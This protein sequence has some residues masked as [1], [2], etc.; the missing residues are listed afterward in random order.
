MVLHT[1]VLVVHIPHT[2]YI[3]VEFRIAFV[4]VLHIEVACT[5]ADTF[6]WA[7]S[8]TDLVSL[9]V[10]LVLVETDLIF[11]Q[12]DLVLVEIDLTP[13]ETDFVSEID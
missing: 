9:G 3:E 12:T 1:A 7:V 11:V 5:E 2:V 10:D 6:D 4:V 13:V 8:G